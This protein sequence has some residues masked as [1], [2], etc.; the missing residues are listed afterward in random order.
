MCCCRLPEEVDLQVKLLT[1]KK[2]NLK[3]YKGIFVHNDLFLYKSTKCSQAIQNCTNTKQ[4]LFYSFLRQCA[5]LFAYCFPIEKVP[6]APQFT[7][8][9]VII[10]AIKTKNVANA[11]GADILKW[12][13][14]RGF[15]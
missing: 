10:F 14:G 8:S 15:F 5:S 4:E 9:R 6:A 13:H 2:N 12:R 3:T 7:F 1:R 11:I